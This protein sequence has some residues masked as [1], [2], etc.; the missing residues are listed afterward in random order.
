MTGAGLVGKVSFVASGAGKVTL[1]T[2]SSFRVSARTGTGVTG[3]DQ[4]GRRA[5]PT[6][7]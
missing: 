3:D 6:T 2:D 1:L 4:A 5:T 7:S